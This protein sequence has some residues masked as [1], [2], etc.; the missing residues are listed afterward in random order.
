MNSLTEP[1]NF[2]QKIDRL[3]SVLNN[4]INDF[5][6]SRSEP[7]KFSMISPIDSV[8]NSFADCQDSFSELTMST[9]RIPQEYFDKFQENLTEIDRLSMR[10]EDFLGIFMRAENPSFQ[11]E[12]T[13]QQI[14]DLHKDTK[15]LIKEN[16][17]NAVIKVNKKLVVLES[18]TKPKTAHLSENKIALNKSETLNNSVSKEKKSENDLER[19]KLQSELELKFLNLS[20]KEDKIRN[21]E[22]ELGYKIQK[23]ESIK[24]EYYAKLGEINKKEFYYKNL[25]RTKGCACKNYSFDI[26]DMIGTQN[27]YEE[28]HKMLGYIEKIIKD[29]QNEKNYSKDQK[30]QEN[31]NK[32]DKFKA[33]LFQFNEKLG[34]F[35]SF[36]NKENYIFNYLKEQMEYQDLKYRELR[37]YEDYLQET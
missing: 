3:N 8:S 4:L 25:V 23:L 17:E 16:T 35:G 37:E 34:Y 24:N 30:T 27:S 33:N 14:T 5:E 21:L 26:K 32:T 13:K 2:E 7:D 11:I 18:L 36:S 20:K 15:R 19:I 29:K 31:Y 12:L 6:H 10:I 28:I 1:E 9:F 22:E